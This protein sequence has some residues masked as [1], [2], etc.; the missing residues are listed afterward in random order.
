MNVL[1]ESVRQAL[2]AV[3]RAGVRSLLTVLGVLIGI[4]AVVTVV[5]LGESARSR[6]DAQIQ[7][8]GS[9]LLYIDDAPGGGAR[10]ARRGNRL[11]LSDADSIRSETTGLSAVTAYASRRMEVQSE[12]DSSRIDV[13]GTDEHYLGVRG[14]PVANGRNFYAS[15]VRNKARVALIGTTAS[16][17][18][19]GA[20]DPLGRSVRIGRHRFEVVGALSHKGRGPFGG[21]PDDCVLVPVTTFLS[22]IAPDRGNRVNTIIAAAATLGGLDRLREQVDLL[23]QERHRIRSG[24][25]RDFR[26]E[27]A[28]G[29]REMQEATFAV[30]SLVLVSVAAI[31]LFVGGLG[32]MNIL[33]V[34]VN[35]RQREI[36]TRLALG[37]RPRDIALQFLVEGTTLT[38][39]GGVLGL[40]LAGAAVAAIESQ[41]EWEMRLNSGAI[42]AA[43][44]TSLSIGLVF[45]M[46]PARRASRLDPI[47]ALRHD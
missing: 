4:A 9:N 38:L 7:Q 31:S 33:L 47:E 15:D 36:G 5:A 30:L 2:G 14:Q 19:F 12:F 10:G 32:V 39:V 28:D 45:G 24:A 8:L 20:D 44:L 34:S 43:L 26:L 17:R 42:A 23:M 35:E 1:W 41:F 37:A 13:G 18:L 21:D 22:R 3:L 40:A 6:V 11:S 16:R 25:K 46:L 29:F 27:T